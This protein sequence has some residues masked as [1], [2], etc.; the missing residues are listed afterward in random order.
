MDDE[1]I[2]VWTA[3]PGHGVGGN[4][5]WFRHFRE[6]ITVK[7]PDEAIVAKMHQI[8]LSLGARVRGGEGEEYGPDGRPKGA[9]PQ[10]SV[11]AREAMVEVLVA[12]PRTALQRTC[13]NV[14]LPAAASRPPLRQAAAPGRRAAGRPRCSS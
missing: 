9:A 3:Y 2:V 11:D 12:P 1:S 5:A 13:R 6:R 8:A 14:I 4:M 10:S 7:N